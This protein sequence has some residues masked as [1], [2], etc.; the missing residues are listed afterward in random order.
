MTARKHGCLR[1]RPRLPDQRF[2]AVCRAYRLRQEFITP[3]TP[4]QN[5]IVERVFRSL[6]EERVW[7]YVLRDV[8]EIRREIRGRHWYD[9]SVRTKRSALTEVNGV[10]SSTQ[11]A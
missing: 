5:G 10:A 1:Q 4:K 11:A 7:Q 9:T 6:K 3:Y 2:A 8:A